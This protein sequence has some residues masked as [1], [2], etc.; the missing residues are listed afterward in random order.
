M[1]ASK[2][3]P[4]PWE[5]TAAK[6]ASHVFAGGKAVARVPAMSHDEAANARLI[7]AAP[8]LLAACNAVSRAYDKQCD[9]N[10]ALSQMQAAIA[11]AEGRA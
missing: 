5:L 6:K 3:T 1:S 2:H 7:A 10:A 4:W 11:K 8:D 9:W